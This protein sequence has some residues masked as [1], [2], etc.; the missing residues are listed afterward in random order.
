MSVFWF[1]WSVMKERKPMSATIV[2]VI[3]G[4]AN[5]RPAVIAGRAEH[6]A[7]CEGFKVERLEMNGQPLDMRGILNPPPSD[8]DARD[9]HAWLKRKIGEAVGAA[10]GTPA[11]SG[12][13]VDADLANA[14]VAS[15]LKVFGVPS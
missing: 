7:V 11:N 4:E 2:L 12:K 8:P 14:V 5:V 6:D 3:S 9:Q 10:W 15:V 1:W 13:I